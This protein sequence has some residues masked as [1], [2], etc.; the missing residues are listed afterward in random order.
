MRT[1]LL[2]GVVLT[3]AC[4]TPENTDQ[5]APS[6]ELVLETQHNVQSDIIGFQLDFTPAR[7]DG[8]EPVSAEQLDD[9]FNV[10][11]D[12]GVFP[13]DVI[14]LE[15]FVD[16]QTR[17][18]VTRM[19][20]QLPEGCYDVLAVPVSTFDET[21]SDFEISKECDNAELSAVRI[22]ADRSVQ[23]KLQSP[24]AM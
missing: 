9:A 21:M 2:S 4:D 15:D 5:I 16:P 1:L 14:F 6:G 23:A 22:Q 19:S 24:C 17:N 13:E 20:I 11:L 12:A 8:R 18:V 10:N 7:C 3:L